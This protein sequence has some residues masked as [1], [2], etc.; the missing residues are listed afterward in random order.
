VLNQ[1]AVKAPRPRKPELR[2]LRCAWG[3]E[4]SG[5]AFFPSFNSR[6]NADFVRTFAYL[7]TT[8]IVI[9]TTTHIVIVT[10]TTPTEK[11]DKEK[12]TQEI[13]IMAKRI[14][15]QPEQT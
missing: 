15:F 5:S 13:E 4:L 6:E 2:S 7:Y 14:T 12:A 10:T 1:L 11:R 3:S 9:A 8:H